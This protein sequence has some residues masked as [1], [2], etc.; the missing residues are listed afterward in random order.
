MSARLRRR[1]DGKKC[2]CSVVQDI[3]LLSRMST[4]IIFTVTNCTT[5]GSWQKRGRLKQVRERGAFKG[6]CSQKFQYLTDLQ[7]QTSFIHEWGNDW[8]NGSSIAVVVLHRWKEFHPVPTEPQLDTW[9]QTTIEKWACVV[10]LYVLYCVVFVLHRYWVS[11]SKWD[12]FHL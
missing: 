4:K 12:S 2:H 9:G 6:P 1:I 10:S 3:K 11:K 8:M 5:V 7:V